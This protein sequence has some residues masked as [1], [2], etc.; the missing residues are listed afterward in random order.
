MAQPGGHRSVPISAARWSATVPSTG[1]PSVPGK[2][3]SPSLA[4]GE[5]ERVDE[6]VD[7]ERFASRYPWRSTLADRLAEVGDHPLVPSIG[8]RHRVS[9]AARVRNLTGFLMATVEIPDLER[10][11]D[12]LRGTGSAGKHQT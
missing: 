8:E 1:S 6:P 7:V 11:A 4:G 5:K 12:E 10:C 9:A 3:D 2:A